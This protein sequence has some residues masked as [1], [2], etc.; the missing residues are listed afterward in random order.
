MDEP[1]SPPPPRDNKRLWVILA[2]VAV[3]LLAAGS[4]AVVA[5]GI[6]GW[7]SV[8][9]KRDAA[10]AA[11][12]EFQT[13]VDQ[14]REKMVERLRSG[15]GSGGEEALGRIKEQLE[16]SATQLGDADAGA[17][18]AMAAFMGTMQEQV[19][20]YQVAA[21]RFTEAQIFNPAF[22]DP[23][24]I[25]GARQVARD[26]I[27]QNARVTDLLERSEDLLRAELDAAQVPSKTRE[28]T[29]KGFMRSQARSRAVQLRVR[30]T[31]HQL[32]EAA[33]AALDLLEKDWGK[34]RH[35]ATSGNIVFDDAATAAAYNSLVEQVQKIA[36]EQAQAQQELAALMQSAPRP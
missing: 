2:V 16:K 23:S 13:A 18:R 34:W 28:E 21:T 26:F 4:A 31:D 7:R 19:R 33:L 30:A 25:A 5:I 6:F 3:L 12:A 27:A 36:A 15:D 17:A 8:Q 1:F 14:E 11:T 22:R 24:A 10:R 35:D 32:G 29:I 20:S 9:T